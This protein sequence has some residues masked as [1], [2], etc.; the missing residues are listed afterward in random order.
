MSRFAAIRPLT[1][2]DQFTG[3]F[4]LAAHVAIVW[5]EDYRDDGVTTFIGE[6]FV[7]ETVAEVA[8]VLTD[9]GYE[10]TTTGSGRRVRQFRCDAIRVD[11][12]FGAYV[13]PAAV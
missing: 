8:R 3:A 5:D 12:A 1:D 10:E 9:Y 2:L 4:P 11:V 7:A 13:V 6:T